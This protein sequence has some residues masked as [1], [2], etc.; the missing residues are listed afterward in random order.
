MH[1]RERSVCVEAVILSHYD[2]GETDRLLAIFTRELGKV[3]AIAKGARKPQ[4]RKAG[5]IE[6][7][8]RSQLQLARGRDLFIVT[9]A[10]NI[11]AYDQLRTDLT[12]LGYAAYCIE[13]LDRFTYEEGEN[14]PLYDLIITTLLRLSTQPNPVFTLRYFEIRLLDLLGF[15]P[16]LF[17]CA[18]CE[19]DIEPEDQFFSA[20]Q[21][22]ILCPTCGRGT[23]GARP[24]T[25]NALKYLRHFQRSSYREAKRAV[26]PPSTH[27]EMEILMQHYLT[28]LLE[29]NL[30]TPSFQRRIQKGEAIDLGT[31]KE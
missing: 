22:G 21:G 10:E 23:G 12:L 8:M 19:A 17:H 25:M 5:H 14:R 28:Y 20:E 24:V 16:H 2:W 31:P 9:Q 15:R 4:S 1:T 29:R 6:P 27:R 3:R 11:E 26:I 13:L 30:N 18:R 7:L